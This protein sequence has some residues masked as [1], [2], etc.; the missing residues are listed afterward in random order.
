MARESRR[1]QGGLQSH[2]A[3][4]LAAKRLPREFESY[5][6]SEKILFVF[7]QRFSPNTPF[8]A[9]TD[10]RTSFGFPGRI[11]PSEFQTWRACRRLPRTP[12]PL[13]ILEPR[14]RSSSAEF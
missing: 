10:I 7:A 5:V 2:R 1:S 13:A 6:A 11:P 9:V 14:T 3:P 4:P 8:R 12:G